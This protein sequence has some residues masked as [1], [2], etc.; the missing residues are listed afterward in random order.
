LRVIT[1]SLFPPFYMS[2]RVPPADI[3][4]IPVLLPTD[5]SINP[6]SPLIWSKCIANR[7]SLLSAI[8]ELSGSSPFMCTELYTIRV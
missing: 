4:V 1:L 6:L 8:M 3:N 7:L 2:P 5:H